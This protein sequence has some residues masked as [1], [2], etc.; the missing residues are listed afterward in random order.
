[1]FCVWDEKSKSKQVKS[2]NRIL[3]HRHAQSHAE[4]DVI[5]NFSLN[6]I[7]MRFSS[8]FF[9]FLLLTASFKS[10][11]ISLIAV[12]FY[13]FYLMKK[14][15]H[16]AGADVDVDIILFYFIWL[17]SKSLEIFVKRND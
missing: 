6:P 8:S 1:V 15:Q 2:S 4:D 16:E 12:N 13:N 7:S 11:I 5:K 10:E 14:I 9:I 3:H 17:V